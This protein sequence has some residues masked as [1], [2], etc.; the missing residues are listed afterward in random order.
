MASFR[1]NSTPDLDDPADHLAEP[2]PGVLE[3]RDQHN[4]AEA[5]ACALVAR[6]GLPAEEIGK[7]F[8]GLWVSQEPEGCY[9]VTTIGAGTI[10]SHHVHTQRR[11]EQWQ[12]SLTKT[13]QEHV[14]HLAEACPCGLET[15]QWLDWGGRCFAEEWVCPFCESG[16]PSHLCPCKEAEVAQIVDP[17]AVELYMALSRIA[18]AKGSGKKS[19]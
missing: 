7:T 9:H 16:L 3:Q 17:F 19:C 13:D 10:I 2:K 4:A 11:Y 15:G 18:R 8:F 1:Q 6:L 5:K 14:R 12:Q